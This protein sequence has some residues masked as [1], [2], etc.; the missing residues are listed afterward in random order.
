MTDMAAIKFVPRVGRKV[1]KSQ[2]RRE[3]I[4]SASIRSL[5]LAA[6]CSERSERSANLVLTL[7]SQ[8]NP[9]PSL[10]SGRHKSQAEQVEPRCDPVIGLDILDMLDIG[11]PLSSPGIA[12]GALLGF[13]YGSGLGV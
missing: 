13:L 6:K 10:T 1:S 3:G 7:L 2:L 4:K 8:P 9:V 12:C 11:G 5:S